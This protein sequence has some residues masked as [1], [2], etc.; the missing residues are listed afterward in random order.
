VTGRELTARTVEQ[1]AQLTFNGGWL[2][3]QA[4]PS[5]QLFFDQVLT[6]GSGT[7]TLTDVTAAAGQSGAVLQVEGTYTLRQAVSDGILFARF[8]SLAGTSQLD[9][10]AIE[11]PLNGADGRPGTVVANPAGI[12]AA[13]QL[14][15]WFIGILA[16]G[17]ILHG[18]MQ[19]VR[20]RG[21]KR[22]FEDRDYIEVLT[23][24]DPFTRRRRFS[25]DANLVKAVSL[26]S[27]EQYKE[28]GLFLGTIGPLDGPDPATQA[29]LRACAAAGQALDADVIAHLTD[30]FRLDPSFREE[31]LTVPALRGYLPY[32]EVARGEA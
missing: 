24:I 27:L 16:V 14:A 17:V 28:A 26:L 8:G 2:E 19:G 15:G 12:N 20:F 3:I 18:P 31:A 21:I 13:W 1:V 6:T 30:C 32:F 29:F 11:L 22:R 4:P 25:R 23:R 5:A 7:A 10:R 9:G